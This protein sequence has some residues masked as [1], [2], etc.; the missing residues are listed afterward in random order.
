MGDS[1]EFA[2]EVFDALARRKGIDATNG[3]SLQELREF[4]EEIS[5]QSLDARFQIFFEM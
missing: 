4:W 1:K 5:S 2:V 3:I